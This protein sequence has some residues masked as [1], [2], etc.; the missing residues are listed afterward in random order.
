MIKPKQR[1]PSSK[2]NEEWIEQNGLYWPSVCIDAID[3]RVADLLLRAANGELNMEDYEHVTNPLNSCNPKHQRYPS[4]IRNYDIIGYIVMLLM[5]E[6][7]RRGINATVVARNSDIEDLRKQ[8]EARL[9]DR[10]LQQ[11]FV[12]RYIMEAQ[13]E[14]QEIDMEQVETLSLE[15]IKRQVKAMPDRL[16]IMGQE[17][18]D[19]IY[20]YNELDSKYAECF[21]YWIVLGR[22]FSYREPFRDE[23]IMKPVSPLEMKYFASSQVRNLEDAEAHVHKVWLPINEAIDKFQD[24]RGFKKILPELEYKLGITSEEDAKEIQHFSEVAPPRSSSFDHL[25][26]TF[27]NRGDDEL[28]SDRY[29]IPVEHVV[30]DSMV[31]VGRVTAVNIFGEI[32]TMEVDEDYIPVAGEEVEW[33]WAKQKWHCYVIDGNHVIGGEPL[34]YTAGTFD[35]PFATKSPYN[36][37]ILNMRHVNPK[38]IVEKGIPYQIKANILHF[39]I[40]KII[41]KNLDHIVVVPLSLLPEKEGLDTEAAMYYAQALSFLFVDDSNKNAQTALNGLKVLNASLSQNLNSLYMMLN[42]VKQEWEDTIGINAP[43]KGQMNA[44]DGKAVTENAVFRSSIM[45]EEYFA[46]FEE[47][48]QRDLQYMLEM[49]KFAFSEGKKAVYNGRDL[50]AAILN[51]DGKDVVFADWNVRVSS[52]GKDIEELEQ[53]KAQAQAIAQ[54]VEG[55]FSQVFK[56]IKANNISKL[57]EEMELLEA[58]I[59]EQ[60]QAEADANRA[61]QERIAQMNAEVAQ[62]QLELDKYKVDQDN[63]TKIEV[64]RIRAQTKLNMDFYNMTGG[65][66]EA[67]AVVE[68]SLRREEMMT[69]ASVDREKSLIDSET[70]KYV[71]DKQLQIAKENKSM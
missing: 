2:K 32:F 24:I 67:A 10:Y 28:Y 30:W 55:R 15:K 8:E 56:T 35:A 6:K 13:A 68:A 52:S 19:Y 20:D 57:I 38:S 37:K 61:S 16:A 26:K 64:E 50:K 3:E 5:G 23:I 21:Y 27:F 22:T 60:V 25:V 36:G 17:I 11:M 43:R 70:K 69:K 63:A 44:S 62:A 59:Q 29:G 65:T 1:I 46:Q 9:Y 18:L 49:S 33:V 41:A 71:V 54:N 58:D 51:V 34:P 12:N 31:K 14:G 45:T 40:E 7:R 42:Y 47:F 66:E 48:Q 39:H 53:A 4:K